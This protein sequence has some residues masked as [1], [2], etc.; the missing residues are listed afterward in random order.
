MK[1]KILYRILPIV[2]ALVLWQNATACAAG[3]E[4]T[5]FQ[6]GN[7]AYSRGDYA[8][9]IA[10][11]E[12]LTASAGLSPAVLFNL[13][14][15]YAQSGKIGKAVVNYERALRLTP[16]D[17]DIIGNLEL[18]RKESGLFD[19]EPAGMA[20]RFL[21]LLSI[22]QWTVL[23][24]VA[25]AGVTLLQVAVLR[26]RVGGKT[27]AGVRITCGLVLI[28]AVAGTLI[29]YQSFR[30]SV[31]VAA[32]ARLLISPFASAASIG[33]IQEGRLVYPQKVHGLFTSVKD[34]TNRQGW[35][36]SASLEEVVPA[37][38]R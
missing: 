14:N 3:N 12:E 31:V 25:L 22:D 15:S 32:D 36:A 24:L 33:A 13:A 5:L 27:S 11:Y 4:E 16:G 23:G 20:I 10:R 1:G 19:S 7:E 34:A 26:Y 29:R 37:Q 8:Q 18:V 38:Y 6:Q 30:P 21:Q 35:I 9:A 17:P 2:F 28:L